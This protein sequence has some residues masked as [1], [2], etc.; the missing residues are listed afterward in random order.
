MSNDIT[1]RT[2]GRAV[3]FTLLLMSLHAALIAPAHTRSGDQTLMLVGGYCGALAAFIVAIT[4]ASAWHMQGAH[5]RAQ[6]KH[7]FI[8]AWLTGAWGAAIGTVIAI[9]AVRTGDSE[10]QRLVGT[11][12]I[13]PGIAALFAA[14][15]SGL[16]LKGLAERA[17]PS[18]PTEGRDARRQLGLAAAAASALFGA[19]HP[20]VRFP[21]VLPSGYEA[22][23]YALVAVAVTTMILPLAGWRLMRSVL[24]SGRVKKH[25]GGLFAPIAGMIVTAV[26]GLAAI[27]VASPTEHIDWALWRGVVGGLL[28]G[29]GALVGASIRR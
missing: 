3:I 23:L 12:M 17:P 20:W 11:A 5:E 24:A 2:R 25:P 29:C 9:I 28:G 16:V 14:R 22:M 26:F 27:G 8:S 1:P 18:P 10:R 19:V 15:F 4:L 7:V 6:L 13:G 21:Q